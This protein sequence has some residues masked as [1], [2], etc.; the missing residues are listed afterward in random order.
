MKKLKK[1][2]RKAGK[3]NDEA[4]FGTRGGG[5][6]GEN[7][8]MRFR[9]KPYYR[10]RKKSGEMNKDEVRFN[11]E[12]ELQQH[13]GLI[14]RFYFEKFKVKLADNTFYTPDFLIVTLDHLEV[15]EV[16]GFLEQDAAVKF[17]VAAELYPWIKWRMIRWKNKQWE[18]IY[19]M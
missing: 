11:E 15:V 3:Q 16:K 18:T 9:A 10:Q 6:K 1:A 19:E 12:L 7:E 14:E 13:A 2:R 8:G 5:L 17:K 4:T